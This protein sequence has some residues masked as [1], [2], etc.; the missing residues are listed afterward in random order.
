M[1]MLDRLFGS[2]PDY[3]MLPTDNPARARLDGM[4]GPLEDLA[5]RVS[6][7]LEVVPADDE[8]FVFLGK[9][10]KRFGIAWLH[11]GKVVGIKELMEEHHLSATDANR[12]ISQIGDAYAAAEGAP[13]Y[14]AD[15]AGKTVVVI[16]SDDLEH[17]VHDLVEAA[18]H[19]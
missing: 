8:A 17:Q 11:D 9:P 2:K 15:I 13:R 18:T 7:P 16:P 5:Q 4:R 1:G 3:P 19:H 12:L 10:P 14:A 6:D